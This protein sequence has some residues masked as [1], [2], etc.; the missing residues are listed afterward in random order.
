MQHELLAHDRPGGLELAAHLQRGLGL[1]G[2]GDLAC[3]KSVLLLGRLV[4]DEPQVGVDGARP[5]G[6]AVA[7]SRV[8]GER[9]VGVVV[10][11]VVDE[12]L[13]CL[14]QVSKAA[15]AAGRVGAYVAAD[16]HVEGGLGVGPD[17]AVGRKV[18]A[19]ARGLPC[20]DNGAVL[21]GGCKVRPRDGRG[22]AHNLRP[23]DEVLDRLL[24]AQ[25]RQHGEPVRGH[26]MDVGELHSQPCWTRL[27]TAAGALTR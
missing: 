16:G 17:H 7:E 14:D 13:Q 25:L 4:V 27:G 10:A 18:R 23:L 3:S 2:H 1:S 9:L 8:H 20:E 22:V 26:Q 5:G 12:D 6:E 11:R 15:A 19:H 24:R 21:R